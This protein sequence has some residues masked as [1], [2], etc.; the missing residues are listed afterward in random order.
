MKLFTPLVI[1]LISCT[2]Y[3]SLPIMTRLIHGSKMRTQDAQSFFICVI[4]SC[5]RRV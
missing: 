2:V 3:M 4:Q 5:H 1:F